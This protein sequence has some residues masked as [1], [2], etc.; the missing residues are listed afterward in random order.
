MIPEY[1]R[2]SWL[3]LFYDVAFVALV[4]QLTYLTAKYHH[5][6]ADFLNFFRR[7]QYLHRVVGHHCQPQ[8]A[9]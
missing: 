7:I 2:A 3:E 5:S 4:A 8:F 9:A 1:K 6:V